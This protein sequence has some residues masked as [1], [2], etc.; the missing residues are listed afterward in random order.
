MST[1]IQCPQCSKKYNLKGRLPA[2]F[3]CTGCQQPMDLTGFPGYEPEPAPPSAPTRPSA[4]SRAG[5]GA[6]AARHGRGRG[7]EEEDDEREGRRGVPPPKSNAP[8]IWA[9]IGGVV[10]AVLVL[11]LVI[12]KK[13]APKP[14]S[15]DSAQGPGSL[16]PAPVPG[17]GLPP[18]LPDATPPG[19]PS[20][21][22]GD[23]PTP[24]TA[25]GSSTPSPA[26]GGGTQPGPQPAQPGR[27]PDAT[28]PRRSSGTLQT[29]AYPDDVTADE[30]QQIDKAVDTVLHDVGFALREAQGVLQKQG[31]KSVWRLISEFKVIH[32]TKTFETKD[33]KQAAM[34]IDRELRRIDGYLERGRKLMDT[35]SPESSPDYVMNVARSWNGWLE[36]GFYKN[37]MKPWDPRVDMADDGA[38]KPAPGRG[39]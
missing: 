39:R 19:G 18:V 15:V 20:G 9:S 22:G 13:G 3:N 23:T 26:P 28:P 31:M 30:R 10:V 34:I 16:A 4:R 17:L 33:G 29:W 37:P 12:N 8:L 27:R 38:E 32:E 6:G 25:P 36:L 2:I 14:P 7:R 5:A 1:L 11:I 35:L 21:P 24:T